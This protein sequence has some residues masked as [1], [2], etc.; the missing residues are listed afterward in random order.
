MTT[1]K[2]KNK[3]LIAVISDTHGLLRDSVFDVF[4]GADII[5]HA[6]DVCGTSIIDK[7]L[8]TAPVIA[9]RG[10][11]DGGKWADQLP[12]TEIIKI[13]NI[14]IYMLHDFNKLDLDPE[15]AGFNIVISG[16]TH[17]PNIEQKNNVLYLNPG[18]AGPRRFDY[19]VSV[20]LL[21]IQGTS[22]KP[23]II[24]IDY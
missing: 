12:E 2:E 10:N 16:H 1:L 23:K 14:L 21:E 15:I 5:L 9:V 20:A 6:G 8:K 3:Y 24:E 11:M 18:S 17:Q 19:P 7:L 13:G 22:L 4:K